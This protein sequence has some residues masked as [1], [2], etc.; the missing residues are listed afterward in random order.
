VGLEDITNCGSLS[1]RQSTEVSLNY[2][3]VQAAVAFAGGVVYT[4]TSGTS[5]RCLRKAASNAFTTRGSKSLPAALVM[6]F[7][8]NVIG[9]LVVISGGQIAK[10]EIQFATDAARRNPR[11]G[12]K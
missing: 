7:P 11:A 9:A 6:V 2:L 8:D 12:P 10:A 3:P 4:R 5:N 1:V